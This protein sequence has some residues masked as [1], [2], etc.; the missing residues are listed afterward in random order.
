[1]TLSFPKKKDI[2]RRITIVCKDPDIKIPIDIAELIA[3]AYSA[4]TVDTELESGAIITDHVINSPVTL[5]LDCFIGSE[6][7]NIESALKGAA[8]SF[9][10]GQATGRLSPLVGPYS[11]LAI[12]AAKPFLDRTSE[13]VKTAY[14][15]LVKLARAKA[16]VDLKADF[17]FGSDEFSSLVITDFSPSFSSQ[18]GDGLSFSLS[19]KKVVLIETGVIEINLERTDGNKGLAAKQSGEQNLGSQQLKDA[20]AAAKKESAS[21][22]KLFKDYLDEVFRGYF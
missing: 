5:Q 1:M 21:I 12:A 7:S 8:T 4:E 17:V 18:S 16:I 19:F 20:S 2:D 14:Q 9:L 22:L 13:R 10:V 3:P 6:P 11:A 15:D